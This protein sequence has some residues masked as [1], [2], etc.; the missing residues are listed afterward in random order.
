M[1]NTDPIFSVAKVTRANYASW[2]YKLLQDNGWS[3]ISSKVSTD[4]YVFNSTG[5]DGTKNYF[6]CINFDTYSS[7][8]FG[9][10]SFTNLISYTPD[11]AGGS[12][13]FVN[14]VNNN[15]YRYPMPGYNNCSPDFEFTVY[16]S[17]TKERV[18]ICTTVS[19]AFSITYGGKR[20]CSSLMYFGM[21]KKGTESSPDIKTNA[22]S[23]LTT[24]LP[25][26]YNGFGTGGISFFTFNAPLYGNNPTIYA[27]YI[28]QYAGQTITNTLA[29]LP[30]RGFVPLAHFDIVGLNSNLIGSLDGIYLVPQT[31]NFLDGD[32]IKVDNATYRLGY[33]ADSYVGV[34]IGFA[35]RIS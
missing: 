29:C 6:I 3:M 1:D 5:E 27:G 21:P 18:I 14:K 15:S 31:M 22:G 16:Y 17:V 13:T 34:N 35:I 32:V 33:I 30:T 4:D 19:Q 28:N 25:C 9:Y 2:L 12:G 8:A 20:I 26:W 23:F 11:G 10:G 24:I 7:C